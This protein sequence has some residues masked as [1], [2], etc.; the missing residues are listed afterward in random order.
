MNKLIILFFIA[1]SGIM[2]GQSINVTF[3]PGAAG[4]DAVLNSATV[5]QTVNFGSSTTFEATRDGH[6]VRTRSLLT[7]DLSSVPA[8]AIISSAK[9]T[10]YGTAHSGTNSAYLRKNTSS[11]SESSV[12]WITAPITTTVNQ[13]S[14]AQ[15]TVATQ[16]YTMDVKTFVQDMV[17]VPATNYG[18]TLIKQD[19]ATTGSL[20]FGSGD[21]TNAALWP[22]L[23]ITYSMPMDVKGYMTPATGA[24]NA[25]GAL[26]VTVNNGVP[27]YTYSWSDASTTKDIYNKLPGLYT[28]TVTDSLGN[29]VKKHMMIGAENTAVTYTITPDELSGKDAL[30]QAKDDGTLVNNNNK[31][32]PQLRA[33]RWTSS[34][35]FKSRSLMAYDLFSIPSN[36]TVNSATL[37]LYGN[38]HNSLSRPN[39]SYL[40]LNTQDWDETSITWA[41]QP[42]HTSTNS[43]YLNGTAS[44]NEN[45][46]I[47]VTSHV[48]SWVQNPSTNFGWKLVLSDEITSSYTSRNYGSSDNATTTLRPSLI[49]S[50]TIPALTDAQRNWHMEET[51]DQNGQVISTQKVYLDDLGRTTQGLS[52]DAN[53]DVFANQ[54]VYDAYGRAALSSLPAYAGNS[55]TYKNNLFLNTAGQEYNYTNFDVAGKI[56]T[57]DPV[58]TGINN[59]VGYYYSNANT[60]DTWQATTSTPYNRTQFMANPMGEVKTTNGADNAFNAASGRE[61]RNYTMLTGDELKFIFGTGNSYMVQTSTVNPLSSTAL[62]L[63]TGSYIKASK[64]ITTSPDNKEV[65]SYSVDGKVIATCMSGL[66]SPDNCSMTS[67]KSYMDWYGTQNTD[68]HIP[69]TNKT[70]LTLPLP[71][72]KFGPNTYTVSSADISY[73]I[74]DQTSETVLHSPMDYTLNTSTRAVTFSTAYLKAYNGKPLFL[75]ISLDYSATLLSTLQSMAVNVPQGI[76]QYN[77]DYGR[78]S[79]N[80][81]DVAGAL[82]KSVSAKGINCSSPGTVSMATVYDYSHLGQMVATQSPDE[83]LVEYA[84][85]TN[86]QLRFSQNAEQKLN[87]RFSYVNYDQHGRT[88]E[89]GEF[90]NQSGSGANGVYFQNYYGAY[91]APYTSNIASS[92]M[93]DNADDLSDTYC[94]DVKHVSYEALSA[95]DDIPAAYTYS[96]NYSGK[97][98]NG[99]VSKTW[100]ENTSTWYKYDLGTGQLIASIQQVNDGDYVAYAGTG[101]AQIKTYETTYDAYFGNVTNSY[102]QKNV[103]GEYA[104]HQYS[105][106]ALKRLSSVNFIAGTGNPA[107]TINTL[108]YD[109]L[110]RLKRQVLGPDLQGVDY[111]YTLNGQIK[112][113]NHPSLDYTKDRGGDN[114]GYNGTGTG[115]YSDL[116]GEILEYYPGDYTRTG[117]SIEANT[118]GLYTGQIYGSRFKTRD[119]VNGTNTG[120]NYIDYMGTNSLQ[121]I[122]TTNYGQQ[123]LANRYTYDAFGQL[124]NSTFGTF[125]NSTNI[126]SARNEYKEFGVTNNS[127]GYDENGNINRLQRNAYVVSGT[128]QLLD[129]LTYT[130]TANTNKHSKV[131]DA[132]V[133]SYA[134]GFNFK[135]ATGTPATIAY[136]AVGQMTVNADENISSI[137]Y[138]PSGQIKQITFSSGNTSTYYYNDQG[139]KYKTKYYN[140]SS[141]ATKYNWY[142][143][144]TV[145]EYISNVGSFDLKQMSVGGSGRAGVYKQDATGIAIGTGHLE[146]ELTDHL[147][148]VRVTFTKGTG[149]TLEVL[150]KNDYY[151]FGGTLPGRSWLQGGGE[152]RFGYQGQ[153]KSQMDVNWDEF[154]LRQYNHDLGRWSAPDPYEQMH[155][156]YVGMGNNP[157]L[158]VDPNG[159]Y[160]NMSDAGQAKAKRWFSQLDEDKYFHRG[161]FSFEFVY[162]NYTAALDKLWQDHFSSSWMSDFNEF[163]FLE[164][165][166]KLNNQFMGLG[167][168]ADVLSSGRD[169]YSQSTLDCKY[170]RD[171]MWDLTSQNGSRQKGQDMANAAYALHDPGTWNFDNVEGA[172]INA[173]NQRQRDFVNNWREEKHRKMDEAAA[174]EKARLKANEEY[175]KQ[176]FGTGSAG[177]VCSAVST[178]TI[179][180]DKFGLN[181]KTPEQW[182]SE[183]GLPQGGR[184][185]QDY[186]IEKLLMPGLVLSESLIINLSGRSKVIGLDRLIIFIS[187]SSPS[188]WQ[189]TLGKAGTELYKYSIKTWDRTKQD[190]KHFIDW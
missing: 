145:Y 173:C 43:I 130:Y 102:F 2:L 153:E 101:N 71:T 41:T 149:T 73:V 172:W 171:L 57:P 64:S 108:A 13:I 167:L 36:A 83:G 114:R 152:Y 50:I 70:S 21:N 30:I 165:L 107:T 127:I 90:S 121:L 118:N 14:L 99:L 28:L 46:A 128:Q 168:D 142:I 68:V 60:L 122:T 119:D 156:P 98:K 42:A 48:Q 182:M 166:Y 51:Y 140:A 10:L 88:L 62:T 16:T 9:L 120:A 137:T 180:P 27:P 40:Y 89:S 159:G 146:Y 54:T 129:N 91:T 20:V 97:Y 77:L 176:N 164:D 184:I 94:N 69:D 5:S 150:S 31:D 115:V 86:G 155:S 131:G 22:K 124:A 18:W 7:M 26:N 148:N 38:G 111:V 113:M 162:A 138:Y 186:T 141:S 19:E 123:E 175:K 87:N 154:E 190:W 96:A 35:W 59:T 76:V 183:R 116:F 58:Q 75:R 181:G 103:S 47:D 104:E 144:G 134:S 161:R 187:R 53:G 12:T 79:V 189:K 136:N 24:S 39:T 8:N 56:T 84:Y 92:T 157:V 15:S 61:V 151:A 85:N 34:G 3:Q 178:S 67:V 160:Y 1:L 6:T 147:G 93:I 143:H 37:Q 55:L 135:N 170:G 29:Q 32:Y 106:D 139:Q 158:M 25:D 66:S 65:I 133:N 52:K 11:W 23:D 125:N 163:H 179:N 17:N 45:T 109:K 185:E 78:W 126:F 112:A 72:Y 110:G 177:G 33:D 95:T 169:E 105:Y 81:Y 100:N 174:A 117:T 44:S 82:R 4:Q 74:T 80:Y 188:N 63:T 132:A 49:I